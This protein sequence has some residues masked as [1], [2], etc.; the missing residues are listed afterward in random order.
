MTHCVIYIKQLTLPVSR[1]LLITY[2]VLVLSPSKSSSCLPLL[3]LVH[4][5]PLW[6]LWALWPMVAL[7]P[8]FEGVSRVPNTVVQDHSMASDLL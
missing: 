4:G 7:C 6:V 3:S 5:F 8:V 1:A 2:S